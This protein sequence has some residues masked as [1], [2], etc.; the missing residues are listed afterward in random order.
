M[1]AIE[2]TTSYL[3]IFHYLCLRVDSVLLSKTSWCSSGQAPRHSQGQSRTQLSW[4]LAPRCS[5]S[6][7]LVS[8][9]L[10]EWLCPSKDGEQDIT[11][12][13]VT[14]SNLYFLATL[15]SWVQIRENSSERESSVMVRSPDSA[16]RELPACHWTLPPLLASCVT[17]CKSQPLWASVSQK[18]TGDSAKYQPH[19]A[20]V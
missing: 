14:H 8:P 6:Y 1:I 12:N 16:A 18:S 11:P 2:L 3:L 17:L 9:N 10:Q 5:R 20:S 15:G 7:Q 4:P 13:T 19:P